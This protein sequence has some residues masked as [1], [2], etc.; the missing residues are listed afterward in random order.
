M[1]ALMPDSNT[2]SDLPYALAFTRFPKFGAASLKKI[3]N[4]FGSF[5]SAWRASSSDLASSEV[6]PNLIGEFVAIRPTISPDAELERLKEH[7]LD[8]V[9]INDEQYPPLLREIHDPPFLFFVRGSLPDSNKS[10]VSIVGS[11]NMTPYGE[12]AIETLVPKLVEAGIGIVSGLAIGCDGAAQHLC[13]ESG[14][15]TYGVL[16]GGCDWDSLS[17]PR[18]RNLA[19]RIIGAGGGIISEFPIGTTSLTHHFPIR[20]RLIAGMTKATIVIEATDKSGS[21]IT[22][23]LAVEQNRD[24]LAVPGPITSET[25]FGP[26]RLIKNGA[27]ILMSAE[28]VFDALQIKPPSARQVK[29]IEPLNAN[30]AAILPLLENDAVHVDDIVVSSRLP[31]NV[32]LQTLTSLELRDAVCHIGGNRYKI[33]GS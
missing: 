13:V 17:P 23:Q 27:R 4:R 3:Y 1:L 5:A 9:T 24:V 20:N 2:N 16:A 19:S 28:D 8:V 25:S 7:G 10:L 30:E 6:H 21:L 22:A 12:R 32:V 15:K 14:G 26:N 11:R 29:K 31:T 33:F 18:H